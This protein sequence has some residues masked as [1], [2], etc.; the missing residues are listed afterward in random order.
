MIAA[1]P[2]TW[3]FQDYRLEE[4]LLRHPAQPE[5]EFIVIFDRENNT[6]MRTGRPVASPA[7]TR[8]ADL[9]DSGV[10][11]GRLEIR[12][13][14]RALALET[15]LVALLGAALG[16]A[17]FIVLRAFP[18]RALRE[19]TEALFREKERAQVTLHSIGDAVITTDT[20][21]RIEYMNPVAEGLTGWKLAEVRGRA[22]SEVFKLVNEVTNQPLESPVRKVIAERRIV[23]LENH[24]ALVRRDG[25][26]VSIEDSAA[27]IPDA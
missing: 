26:L 16:G 13:S 6:V 15:A 19:V 12:R 18:L 27:P 14:V 21:E 17:V 9:F 10:K 22:L 3:K 8:I 23:P 5:D 11:V 2:R 20:E 4:L 7:L 25:E 24:T 1:H